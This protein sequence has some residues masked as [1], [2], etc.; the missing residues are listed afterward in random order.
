MANQA[1]L[2]AQAHLI[3]PPELD[4]RRSRQVAYGR[5]ERAQEVF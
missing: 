3:L 4:W 2:L 1:V 5:G